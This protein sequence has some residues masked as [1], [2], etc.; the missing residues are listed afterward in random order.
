MTTKNTPKQVT[1][2]VKLLVQCTIYPCVLKNFRG[3][4]GESDVEIASST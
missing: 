4:N 3:D 2:L 1:T